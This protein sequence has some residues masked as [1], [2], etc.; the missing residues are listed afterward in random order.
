MWGVLVVITDA[1]ERFLLDQLKAEVEEAVLA[2]R[3]HWKS[4]VCK[5]DREQ[6]IGGIYYLVEE[7]V[8]TRKGAEH[9]GAVYMQALQMLAERDDKQ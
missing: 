8:K 5:H 1:R 7:L 2:I 6:C 3:T 9:V 4:G